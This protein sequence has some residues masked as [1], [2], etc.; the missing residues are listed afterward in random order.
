MSF[1]DIDT[2][3]AFAKD[4][5]REAMDEAGYHVPMFLLVDSAGRA[6]PCATPWTCDEEKQE[7]IEMMTHV[8]R[9]NGVVRYAAIF[10]CYTYATELE[11][12][13]KLDME[14]LMQARDAARSTRKDALMI[15]CED[16]N[17]AKRGGIYT[18][19][20]DADGKLKCA[21][22]DITDMSLSTPLN[23]IGQVFDR[24]VAN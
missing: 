17:G 4:R 21:A 9:K 2:L 20:P 19:E 22:F 12:V 16:V 18:C 5:A 10:E 24:S 8:M 1:N 15:V 14:K 23:G 3:F 13:D 11:G 7:A 6:L